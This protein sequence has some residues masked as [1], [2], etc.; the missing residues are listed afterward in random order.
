MIILK[1]IFILIYIPIIFF[2][3]FILF[4]DIYGSPFYLILTEKRISS[5]IERNYTTLEIGDV[6]YDGEYKATVYD[7]YG[8]SYIMTYDTSKDKVNDTYYIETVTVM[9][10]L[11][12][13]NIRQLLNYNDINVNVD[14]IKIDLS[15]PMY[16]Y[17]VGE[18]GSDD[19]CE[20]NL[21]IELPQKFQNSISFGKEAYIV[22][23]TLKYSLIKINELTTIGYSE[24]GK[25]TVTANNKIYPADEETTI[26][27]TQF[28]QID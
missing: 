2:S 14:E 23:K 11:I 22:F 3:F 17:E 16:V 25:Y 27:L 18:I 26:I 1:R 19:E 12:R 4:S 21:T 10:A 20:C 6:F 13:N 9:T 24:N 5:Y 28:E 7:K 8:D 15:V